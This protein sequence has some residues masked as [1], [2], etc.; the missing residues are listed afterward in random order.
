M[1]STKHDAHEIQGTI[2]WIINWHL[3]LFVGVIR[4]LLE[5]SLVNLVLILSVGIVREGVGLR[6]I[7]YLYLFLVKCL[8]A[9]VVPTFKHI[10]S[11]D[12]A[13]LVL[14]LYLNWR[15]FF[16]HLAL[17]S[18]ID[19]LADHSE[20][21]KC[22]KWDVR[23]LFALLLSLLLQDYLVIDI[24]DR[25]RFLKRKDRLLLVEFPLQIN[26]FEQFHFPFEVLEF[27]KKCF[28]FRVLH[29]LTKERLL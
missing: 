11:V 21:Q 15:H 20:V 17:S 5:S 3:L 7:S 9:D 2:Q 25:M 4:A 14:E 26:D 8:I 18:L 6:Q 24:V 1:L 22:M 10:H 19:A 29:Y 27:R 28:S 13:A 23:N 16:L 12:L